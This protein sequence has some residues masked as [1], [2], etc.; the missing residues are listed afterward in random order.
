VHRTRLVFAAVEDKFIGGELAGDGLDGEEGGGGADGENLR[1]G[2]EF[3]V[4]NLGGRG[5]EWVV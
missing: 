2:G 4:F 5:N 3:F 1:K